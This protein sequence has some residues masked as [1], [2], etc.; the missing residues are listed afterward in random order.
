[1][2]AKPSNDLCVLTCDYKY[3]NAVFRDILNARQGKERFAINDARQQK[4]IEPVFIA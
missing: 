4:S 3:Q 2:S 1:M